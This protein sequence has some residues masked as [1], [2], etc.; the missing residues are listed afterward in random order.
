MNATDL[1]KDKLP[2]ADC[3]VDA[4]G[5]LTL[6]VGGLRGADRPRLLLRLRP[7]RG[8]EQ[9]AVADRPT[10]EVGLAPSPDE[11]GRWRAELN[12]TGPVL[13]EGRWDV[14][15][16]PGG[17][18]TGG[19]L[20]VVPGAR[21]LRILASGGFPE[22]VLPLEARVPYATKDGYFS[23][24]AWRRP[25]HAEAGDLTVRDGALT[26]TGR[27]LGARI[28]R[29]ARALLKRR[30]KGGPQ[31]ETRLAD[32]GEGAFTF[33]AD[34]AD[35]PHDVQGPDPAYWD[36]YLKPG[37]KAARVR[38]ARLL[39]DVADKKTVFVYPTTELGRVTIRPYYTLDNDLAVQVSAR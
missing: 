10:H 7:K 11:P 28:G 13:D 6:E 34:Y 14:W 22:P 5:T 19:E 2:R 1:P 4:T 9:V 38:V 31:V 30:G 25:T 3:A 37:G 18:T 16:A 8:T 20:R 27:L 29:G 39:D 17:S 36:V 15:V 35:I 33:R 12:G 23:I 26:V 32:E 21:D 24:R